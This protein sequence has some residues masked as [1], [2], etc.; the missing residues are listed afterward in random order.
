MTRVHG[1]WRYV[2]TAFSG[3]TSS[4]TSA[5]PLVGLVSAYPCCSA[6]LLAVAVI[7]AVV[8]ALLVVGLVLTI[9]CLPAIIVNL[10]FSYYTKLREEY[11]FYIE[12]GGTPLSDAQAKAASER[13]EAVT[14]W[15][16]GVYLV[17]LIAWYVIHNPSR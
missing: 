5:A 13:G 15:F 12:N 8:E 14:A 4:G 16:C 2:T 10:P 17:G 3:F 1:Y 7:A 11:R 9:I 6:C